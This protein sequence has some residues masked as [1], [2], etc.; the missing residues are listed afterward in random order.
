[1]NSAVFVICA[2]VAQWSHL[3]LANSDQHNHLP[4]VS[5][6]GYVKLN[7]SDGSEM[8]YA[9]YEAQ[10]SASD[11]TP[12][13]LWLQVGNLDIAAHDFSA[14]YLTERSCRVGQ[15]AQACLE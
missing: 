14:L 1:M 8:F 12:I 15:G 4:D 3:V 13:L 10:E 7:K 5:S 9:Y 6:S 2:I 11:A